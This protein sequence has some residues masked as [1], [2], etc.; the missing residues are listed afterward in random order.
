MSIIDFLTISLTHDKW[1]I[2]DWKL[3]GH[4]T[5]YDRPPGHK[6]AAP[7]H[8]EH[9]VRFAHFANRFMFTTYAKRQ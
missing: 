3:A 2:S 4:N 1:M 9:Y 8:N 6:Q 7:E 5:V